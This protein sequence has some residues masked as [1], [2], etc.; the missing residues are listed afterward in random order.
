MAY[1][2]APPPRGAKVLKE[3]KYQFNMK[4]TYL[5]PTTEVEVIKVEVNFLGSDPSVSSAPDLIIDSEVDPW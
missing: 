2:L 5:S 3:Y 1:S 4:Q